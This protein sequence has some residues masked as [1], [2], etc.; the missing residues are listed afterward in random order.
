MH[1]YATIAIL[2]AE[3]KSLTSPIQ[4]MTFLSK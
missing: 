4:M 2:G 3:N 1:V